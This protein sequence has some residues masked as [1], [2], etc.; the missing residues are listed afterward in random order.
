[1]GFEVVKNIYLKR[2][3]EDIRMDVMVREPTQITANGKL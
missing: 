3:K 1:M 2:D